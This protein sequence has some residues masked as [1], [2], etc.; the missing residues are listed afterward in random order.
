MLT[1]KIQYSVDLFVNNLTPF[2][3]VPAATHATILNW[4]SVKTAPV[5]IAAGT[6]SAPVARFE[7]WWGTWTGTEGVVIYNMEGVGSIGLMV[8]EPWIGSNRCRVRICI[9]FIGGESCE[10]NE[11]YT[12]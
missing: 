10:L 11:R 6:P 8:N 12:V 5:P 3:W 2:N 7:S 4:G 9:H 1:Y